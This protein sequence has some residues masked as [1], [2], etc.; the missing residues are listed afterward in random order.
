MSVL[1]NRQQRRPE[2]SAEAPDG[3]NHIWPGVGSLRQ[4]AETINKEGAD[5]K[6]VELWQA[7]NGKICNSYFTQSGQG[8]V[9][10]TQTGTRRRR[11]QVLAWTSEH[12][13]AL[14]VRDFDDALSRAIWMARETE[15]GTDRLLPKRNRKVVADLIFTVLVPL[16]RVLGLVAARARETP[17]A[18]E[19]RGLLE[20]AAV[21]AQRRL[22][23]IETYVDGVELQTA[24]RRYLYGLPLGFAVVVPLVLMFGDL[25]AHIDADPSRFRAVA[26][27]GGLGSITSVMM[28]ITT[29]Q[30][31]TVD[32]RQGP[33]VTVVSGAFR[34]LVGSVFG[35][36]L[37][38]LVEGDL[39]PI[40]DVVANQSM[41][42]A[43]L[44]FLAGFSERWAQDTIVRSAPIPTSPTVADEDGGAPK[45][46]RA[47]KRGRS[48]RGSG[49]SPR[50][51]GARPTNGS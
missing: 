41:F 21:S 50:S 23:D 11:R 36:A 17:V 20:R 39:I 49:T 46:G 27:A 12:D 51:N 18:P 40:D 15:R 16:L 3:A 25:V 26:L 47:A 30:S 6:F 33:I 48:G 10:I 35:I 44:A 19:D 8:A 14:Q 38:V 1:G 4:L 32:P 31:L 2:K 13:V 7:V 45:Q 43:G 34:T 29:G 22:D 5:S 42:Y 24:V 28:R 37:Y 9:V